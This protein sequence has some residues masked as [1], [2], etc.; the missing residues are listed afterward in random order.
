MNDVLLSVEGVSIYTL[1]AFIFLAYLWSSFV[2]YKKAIEYNESEETV[3]N[4]VLLM[5][6]LSFIF[7][8]LGFV[9]TKLDWFTGHW[10]RVLFVK[11]YPGMVGWGVFLGVAVGVLIMVR[12]LKKK[13]F[14]WLD[15]VVLGLSA[16]I[17]IVYAAKGFLSADQVVGGMMAIETIKG[18]LLA[19]WF[20]F[21]WWAERE[22]RTFEWYRFRKTQAKTGFVTGVFVFGFGLINLITD[23]PYIILVVV[24][25]LV[26]YIRSERKFKKDL[27]LLIKKK[28]FK[29]LR[30]KLGRK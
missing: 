12:N 29:W 11:E 5:G 27:G 18:L 8:R 17:P 19:L 1:S 30:K 6:A 23:W 9:V 20:F 25:A 7:A 16:G 28:K 22:Y 2:F 3:F 10:I 26:V 15:L 21:L 13:L 24:G 14:N 4:A